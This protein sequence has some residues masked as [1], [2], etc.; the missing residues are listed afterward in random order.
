LVLVWS[1][2]IPAW[3]LVHNSLTDVYS[4]SKKSPATRSRKKRTG[5]ITINDDDQS[6]KCC[7]GNKM[8]TSLTSCCS[9][10]PFFSIDKFL[11]YLK[12]VWSFL[13]STGMF[14]CWIWW[15]FSHRLFN[16]KYIL[17]T[18]NVSFFHHSFM[19][20]LKRSRG[21][22][23]ACMW[24]ENMLIDCQKVSFKCF[25]RMLFAAQLNVLFYDWK[26]IFSF[27]FSI[28]LFK[29][30]FRYQP[31]DLASVLLALS[32]TDVFIGQELQWLCYG[33][34]K[35]WAKKE[36]AKQPVVR[37]YQDITS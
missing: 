12:R 9:L 4:Y 22:T 20:S 24:S 3:N 10:L 15:I 32:K 34:T 28:D 6:G 16:S 5:T 2:S 23:C 30:K 29:S 31:Q 33:W 35:A 36:K 14:D 13:G 7:C 17:L 27:C 21:S 25:W 18:Q 37:A 19:Q 1:T 26:L 11:L 8:V